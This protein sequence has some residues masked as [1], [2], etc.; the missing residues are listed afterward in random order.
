[1]FSHNAIMARFSYA[2]ENHLLF[3]IDSILYYSSPASV[4][5]S[6]SFFSVQFA[7]QLAQ[8]TVS[9]PGVCVAHIKAKLYRYSVLRH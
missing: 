4:L 6:L 7:F 8:D 3:Y 9:D 1:M 5:F 2:S